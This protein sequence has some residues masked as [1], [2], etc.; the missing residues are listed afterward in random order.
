[1]LS[2]T[3]TLTFQRLTDVSAILLLPTPAKQT[4]L[5]NLTPLRLWWATAKRYVF[6]EWE[7]LSNGTRGVFLVTRTVDCEEYIYCFS[8]GN[9]GDVTQLEC[10]FVFQNTK[11]KGNWNFKRNDLCLKQVSAKSTDASVDKETGKQVPKASASHYTIAISRFG[12]YFFALRNLILHTKA[13]DVFKYCVS[14]GS[15][16]KDPSPKIISADFFT[17]TTAQVIGDTILRIASLPVELCPCLKGCPIGTWDGRDRV[18]LGEGWYLIQAPNAAKDSKVGP[19]YFVELELGECDVEISES[20]LSMLFL[21][22]E[23]N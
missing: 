8:K 16:A 20:K 19:G 4:V 7:S 21:E 1:M 15:P 3:L 9:A 23:F 11:G 18:W 10:P 5:Q 17:S 12:T 22:S 2:S 14:K 13:D 6:R